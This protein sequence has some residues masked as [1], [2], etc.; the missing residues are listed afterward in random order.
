MRREDDNVLRKAL[1]FKL[2]GQKK[3]G[4]PKMTRRIQMEKEIE[5][6]GLKEKNVSN[7]TDW[8]KG[9]KKMVMRCAA[10]LVRGE[11]PH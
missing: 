9:M 11:T 7:R 4:R 3:R 5:K 1:E 8:R 10:T 6:V 2:H